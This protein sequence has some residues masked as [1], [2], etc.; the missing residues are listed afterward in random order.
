[1]DYFSIGIY[2]L[3]LPHLYMKYVGIREICGRYKLGA[4]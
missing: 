3:H 4:K 2:I 1:M